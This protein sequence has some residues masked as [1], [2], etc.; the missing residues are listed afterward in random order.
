M[1]KYKCSLTK[2]KVWKCQSFTLNLPPSHETLNIDY[3]TCTSTRALNLFELGPINRPFPIGKTP[4]NSQF[5]KLI[6]KFPISQTIYIVYKKK[7]NCVEFVFTYNFL[8][9]LFNARKVAQRQYNHTHWCI[10]ILSSYPVIINHL[11]M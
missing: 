2:R 8:C 9:I 6:K 3:T 4:Q 7:L 11:L 5:T 10:W 1:K